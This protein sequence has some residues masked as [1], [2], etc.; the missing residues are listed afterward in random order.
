MRELY[1]RIR[2]YDSLTLIFQERVALG[3]FS[4]K[5]MEELL[6][7]LVAKA[8]L[9]NS[10]IVGAYARRKTKIA[11]SLLKVHRDM[12]AQAIYTC[13]SN[14]HFVADVIDGAGQSSDNQFE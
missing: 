14:P 4:E 8:S 5:Q 13:G 1:W 3:Q 10:E 7:A 2:G 12:A 11:N 6:R 9:S